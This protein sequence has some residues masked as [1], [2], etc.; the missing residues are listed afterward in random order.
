MSSF[1]KYS[2][3]KPTS[4]RL[5][6]RRSLFLIGPRVTNRKILVKLQSDSNIKSDNIVTV[7]VEF[8]EI[9]KFS[10]RTEMQLKPFRKIWLLASILSDFTRN[11]VSW[12]GLYINEIEEI[13]IFSNVSTQIALSLPAGS[14][15]RFFKDICFNDSQ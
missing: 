7:L 10:V 4:Y 13:H 12:R 6:M 1:L 9:Y 11:V 3:G 2:S 8:L 15:V 14:V 5:P